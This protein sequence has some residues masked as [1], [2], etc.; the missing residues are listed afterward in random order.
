MFLKQLDELKCEFFTPQQT[1]QVLMLFNQIN[2]T[3]SVHYACQTNIS[4]NPLMLKEKQCSVLPTVVD[5]LQVCL[6]LDI[7]TDSPAVEENH[8]DGD[9]LRNKKQNR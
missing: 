9:V 4:L 3:F 6:L 5:V 8:Q 1:F 2:N 7:D